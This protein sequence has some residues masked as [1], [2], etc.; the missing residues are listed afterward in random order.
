MAFNK[1]EYMKKYNQ[2]PQYKEK[3]KEWRKNN[4]EYSKEWQRNKNEK[5]KEYYKNYY[6]DK[7]Q[8]DPFYKLK[9]NIR[10]R[11]SQTL[12]EYSKS[13]T[14][15]QILGVDDFNSFKKYLENQFTEGMNWD[16][17]GYGEGKWVIDHVIPISIAST[18]EEIYS[19]NHYSNLQPMW[20]KE[21]M[22][23]SDNIIE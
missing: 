16:N 3:R 13:K 21:N 7:K 1:K 8:N 14:T 10:T 19:L 17:Y 12:S 11:I 5:T 9:C 6:K 4:P 15:L 2:L 23:K 22:I 18:E 20:W